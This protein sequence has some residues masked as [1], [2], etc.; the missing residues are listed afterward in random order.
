M[1]MV[2][3]TIHILQSGCGFCCLPI[4][5]F[6][7]SS[8]ISP[9]LPQSTLLVRCLALS[10]FVTLW[11]KKNFL[12]FFS[13]S[14]TYRALKLQFLWI[15]LLLL[16]FFRHEVPRVF[17]HMCPFFFTTSQSL[18][19]TNTDYHKYFHMSTTFCDINFFTFIT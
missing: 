18:C 10:S 6:F 4:F 19:V 2:A 15:L 11:V 5:T 9:P 8:V 14:H 16:G 12:E 7:S 3:V 17:F 1:I 13:L